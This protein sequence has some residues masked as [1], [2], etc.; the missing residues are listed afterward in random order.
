[1]SII[2]KLDPLVDAREF[3]AL[4][5]NDES[6]LQRLRRRGAQIRGIDAKR[7]LDLI[8]AC[9]ALVF[10]APTMAAI[11]LILLV[12]G[13]SPIFAHQRVGKDGKLFRCFKFRSMVRN[14]DKV[15]AD[16]L[17]ANPAAKEEWDRTFKLARDPRVKT[18]GNFLRRS[19]LDELPQLFNVLRGDMSLVGPRPIVVNEIGRY[20]N[21]IDAYYRCRPGITGLWQVS[22]RNDCAYHRR[23]RLDAVYSRKRSVWLDIMI[24]ARTVR[25]VTSGRGAY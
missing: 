24:L 5:G 12:S 3:D 25:A 1:M 13:G 22:G 4:A 19:S 2:Q 15:L 10:F 11:H 6:V 17:A 9:C 8:G 23:V 16:H 20:A 21:R 7:A 14:A 18:F